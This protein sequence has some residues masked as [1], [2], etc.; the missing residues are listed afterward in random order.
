[1]RVLV[2]EDEPDLNRLLTRTLTREG[3]AVDACLRG[4]DA[5]DY[6]RLA[7]Y[8]AVVLDVLLPGQSGIEVLRG[9]RGRGDA[10]PVLLLTALDGISDRV[11]GLDA[12]ADDY[13]VK[14]FSFD[15]LLA[16]LRVLLRRGTGGAAT[17]QASV[18]DLTV[19]F[20]AHRVTRGGELISLTSREFAVLEFLI[21]NAGRVLTR[22]RIGQSIWNYD[23]EG[24]S[25]VVDVYIRCLRKKLDDGRTPKLIH[26]VRG[27]GYVLEERT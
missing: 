23:Y 10:T 21:R 4:D 12:G 18:A 16:R 17:N 5:P 24:E 20:D 27:T 25:N 9:M 14:P 11:K 1:M 26:T 8:D 2:V 3:Y 19:D 6:L 15:E 13:L 22:D 7:K